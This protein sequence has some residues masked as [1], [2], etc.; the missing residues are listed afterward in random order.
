MTTSFNDPLCVHC[1][2]RPSVSPLG[3]CA[4]CHAVKGIRLLYVRRRGWTPQW[5]L[6]LRR[7]TARAQQGLP[8]FPRD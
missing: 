6:H 3:L 4:V 5:E 8:L 7:L 1:E 2:Q